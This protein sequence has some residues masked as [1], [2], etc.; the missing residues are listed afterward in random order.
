[1]EKDKEIEKAISTSMDAYAKVAVEF[2]R[3]A[4]HKE[5]LDK[6]PARFFPAQAKHP[7]AVPDYED[8]WNECN[9]EVR[10]A[11]DEVFSCKE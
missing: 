8:G 6:L 3:A 7:Y 4:L 10:K 1:M 9:A 2:D 5:L 11:I